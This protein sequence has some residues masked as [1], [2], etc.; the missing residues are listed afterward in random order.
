MINND[1]NLGYF[2]YL[3]NDMISK[4]NKT[5]KENVSLN[6]PIVTESEESIDHTIGVFFT[7]EEFYDEIVLPL[8][9]AKGEGGQTDDGLLYF[10]N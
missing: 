7:P 9:I 5:K 4:I 3:S 8:G 6:K 2:G 10:L 1:F